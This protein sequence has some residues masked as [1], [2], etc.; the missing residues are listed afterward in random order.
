MKK[1]ISQFIRWHDITDITWIYMISTM[2]TYLLQFHHPFDINCR[3][4][5][6]KKSSFVNFQKKLY[7]I[8][9]KWL[10]SNNLYKV[11]CIKLKCKFKKFKILLCI[12]RWFTFFTITDH[13]VYQSI[14]L[15]WGGKFF[16]K[17]INKRLDEG[18]EREE[19]EERER[20]DLLKKK[21]INKL[22]IR[23]V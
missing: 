7:S 21:S 17:V 23:S 9:A 1:I 16:R 15:T 11:I 10:K 20:K 22:L 19:E 3:P 5:Q 13:W 6:G 8:N 4:E 18:R 14:M 2:T 12:K